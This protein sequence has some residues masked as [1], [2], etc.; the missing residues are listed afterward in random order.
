VDQ[1]SRNNNNGNDS[2]LKVQAKKSNSNMRALVRFDLPAAPQGCAVAS[3]T[4]RLYAAS[5]T[6]GR[7]LQVFQLVGGWSEGSVTWNNQPETTGAAVTTASGSGWRQWDVSALVEAMYAGANHGFLVRDAASNGNGFEQQFHSREKG[8]NVPQLVL[9]FSE[10][11]GAASAP[12]AT[13][14]LA[15]TATS[16]PTATPTETPSP[17]ATPSATPTALATPTDTPSAQGT[18]SSTPTPTQTALP[19]QTPTATLVNCG[20]PVSLTA[21]ADAWLDENSAGNNYGGDSILKVQSKGPSDNFRA[22]VSFNLP[23][24]PAGCIVQS[25]SLRLYAPSANSGRTLEAWQAAAGWTESTVAWNNQPATVGQAAAAAA[26]NGWNTWNV[27]AQ[28]QSMYAAGASHG[29]LIRDA[30]EGGGGFEQQFHSREKGETPPA[31]E[32]TFGPANP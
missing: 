26:A 18:P 24:L 13:S 30:A 14:T 12:T 10:A 9:T 16:T 25:A 6:N 5:S 21:A 3:A 8:E 2:I 28:V 1:G 22:L 19:T 15:P 20:G 27:T 17:S 31:L 32:I 4:L 29:F 11:A 7:T 23:S